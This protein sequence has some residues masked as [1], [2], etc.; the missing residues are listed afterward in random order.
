MTPEESLTGFAVLVVAIVTVVVLLWGKGKK[1][2]EAR[3]REIEQK[4]YVVDFPQERHRGTT[5]RVWGR[6]EAPVP[7]YLHFSNRD[8]NASTAGRIGI[9]DLKVGHVEFDIAFFVRSNKPDWALQFL[10]GGLCERLVRFESIQFCTAAIG[11]LLTPDY[12]P[13]E[14]D[15]DRRDLWMLRIDGRHEGAALEPYVALARELSLA[16]QAFCA[17]KAHEAADLEAGSFEGR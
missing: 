9:A 13:E 1:M 7:F 3:L 11:S 16:V 5:T 17:G 2:F 6:Y 10:T 15:R 8:P 12:W 4:G 14:K